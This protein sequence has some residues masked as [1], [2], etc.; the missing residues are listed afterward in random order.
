MPR[1]FYRAYRHPSDPD[2]YRWEVLAHGPVAD[3]RARLMRWLADVVDL[4]VQGD[5]SYDDLSWW[6]RRIVN[7]EGELEALDE[8]LFWWWLRR[9]GLNPTQEFGPDDLPEHLRT[10][11]VWRWDDQRIVDTETAHVLVDA[12]STKPCVRPPCS[13]ETEVTP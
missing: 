13:P 9:N 3:A 11:Y 1:T 8:A 6:R 2:R 12:P 4:R 7:A 5:R 10:D